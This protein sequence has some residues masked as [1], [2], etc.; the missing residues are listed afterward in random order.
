[1]REQC[2]CY[3]NTN[4]CIMQIKSRIH[5]YHW[6]VNS[7]VHQ[8]QP[9]QKSFCYYIRIGERK[10]ERKKIN[11]VKMV[12]SWQYQPQIMM[13]K[14]KVCSNKIIIACLGFHHISRTESGAS[15]NHPEQITTTIK[16]ESNSILQNQTHYYSIISIF[17]F[18]Y[19]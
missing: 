10:K 16:T 1:M 11:K 12:C 15:N 5:P 18:G 13:G 4:I 9:F 19:M 6:I 8:N 3:N 2:S 14:A 17:I 7:K